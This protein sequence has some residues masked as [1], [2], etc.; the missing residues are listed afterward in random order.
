MDSWFTTAP[1]PKE[2]LGIGLDVVGMVKQLKQRYLYQG[3]SYT[4]SQLR[5]FM[6]HENAVNIFGSVLVHTRDGIPVKIVFIRNWNK[7]SK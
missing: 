4:L 2:I 6:R 5:K 3:K 7:K 1:I